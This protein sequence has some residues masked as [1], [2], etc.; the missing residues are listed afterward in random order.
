MRVV[1][2]T[3]ETWYLSALEGESLGTREESQIHQCDC[4]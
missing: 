4:L 1:K 2:V 3:G